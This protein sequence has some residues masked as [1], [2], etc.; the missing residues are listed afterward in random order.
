MFM[1]EHRIISSNPLMIAKTVK[2]PAIAPNVAEDSKSIKFFI[3]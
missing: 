3:D 1:N 2:S